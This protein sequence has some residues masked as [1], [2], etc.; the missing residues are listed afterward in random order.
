MLDRSPAAIVSRR[1][2]TRTMNK[3]L[4]TLG[5]LMLTALGCLAA[6]R[7][8]S[9]REAVG[10]MMDTT[11]VTISTQDTA[12]LTVVKEVAAKRNLKCTVQQDGTTFRVTVFD[13]ALAQAKPSAAAGQ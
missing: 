2:S 6:D 9:Y 7:L 5:S 4:A 12:K 11:P 10:R 8:D 3:T 1:L 13:S